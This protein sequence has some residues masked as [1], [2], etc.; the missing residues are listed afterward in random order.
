[1]GA[2]LGT[3]SRATRPS[4]L[5]LALAGAALGLGWGVTV[6]AWMRLISTDPEFSWSG[7]GYILG[8][9]TVIGLLLG[10]A[11]AGRRRGA[12]R[13]WRATGASALLLGVGAGIIVVPTALLGGLA[14]GRRRWHPAIRAVLALAAAAPA[15]LVARDMWS[16]L[17]PLR[18]GLGVAL[19]AALA[20]TLVLGF[21]V[22]FQQPAGSGPR[23]PSPPEGG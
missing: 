13:W 6:R 4:R 8:A 3:R 1:M 5:R 21:S 16:T 2:L 18:G 14:A 10:A 22:P 20:V 7:T 15:V 11:E 19:W 12:M 23:A 17:P 9:C